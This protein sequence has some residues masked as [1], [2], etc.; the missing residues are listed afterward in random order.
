MEVEHVSL[1]DI[2]AASYLHADK[3][4]S[5]PESLNCSNFLDPAGF[6]FY[7]QVSGLVLQMGIAFLAK[8]HLSLLSCKSQAHCQL[9]GTPAQWS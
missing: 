4:W 1:Q 6:A 7:L 9:S 3:T 2:E 8:N 5:S